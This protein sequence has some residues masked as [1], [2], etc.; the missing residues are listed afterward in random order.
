MSTLTHKINR[1]IYCIGWTGKWLVNGPPE[2]VYYMDW[3]NDGADIIKTR[4][5]NQAVWFLSFDA[6]DGYRR[7]ILQLPAYKDR[8]FRIIKF[9]L[10]EN[11][12]QP[13]SEPVHTLDDRKIQ[14]EL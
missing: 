14:L 9:E 1:A 10:S 5:I 4:W 12:V 13:T 3:A 11:P 7:T 8:E 2:E 6:A